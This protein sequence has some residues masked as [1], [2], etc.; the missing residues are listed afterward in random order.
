MPPTTLPLLSTGDYA[1]KPRSMSLRKDTCFF[2]GIC[3][4]E[5]QP[6]SGSYTYALLGGRLR[7]VHMRMYILRKYTHI[8]TYKHIHTLHTTQTHACRYGLENGTCSY[9][10]IH[11]ISTLRI[12]R[13]FCMYLHVS[14]CILYVLQMFLYVL[15]A[16][17]SPSTFCCKNTYNT[18]TCSQY[19]CDTYTHTH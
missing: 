17:R 10:L 14:V 2:R 18:Y 4:R 11:A 5:G 12:L 19:H 13:F 3:D 1:T 9:M 6:G 15:C 8:C 16:Y 7:G